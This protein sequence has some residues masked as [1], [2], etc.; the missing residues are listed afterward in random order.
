MPR[1]AAGK[2]DKPSGV[3]KLT[4]ELKQGGRGGIVVSGAKG[5]TYSHPKLTH[6]SVM[7]PAQEQAAKQ[8]DP[9]YEQ[10][11]GAMTGTWEDW[12]AKNPQA[13]LLDKVKEAVRFSEAFYKARVEVVKEHLLKGGEGVLRMKV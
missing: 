12:L 7:D 5:K 11:K 3:E 9:G 1:R 4:D 13:A 8:K 10:T 6:I 2:G